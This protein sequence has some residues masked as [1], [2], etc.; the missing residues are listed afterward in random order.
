MRHLVEAMMIIFCFGAAI[1]YCITVGDILEPVRHLSYMPD[2]VRGPNGRS[3]VMV[4]FWFCLM[5]PLSLLRSVNSL[6]FSSFLGVTAIVFLV[7]ATIYHCIHHR[8]AWESAC[9]GSACE[10]C[11]GGWCTITE[12]ATPPSMSLDMFTS[13]PLIMFA[14][15]CQVNVYDIYRE[16]EDATEAK[17]MRISWVGMCGICLWVYLAMGVAGYLDF[18]GAIQGNILINLQYAVGQ[19]AVVTGAFIC[20]A[21]T[22]VVAFPLCV[23]PCRESIFSIMRGPSSDL[24]RDEMIDQFR[25]GDDQVVV[26]PAAR[27][28]VSIAPTPS[29]PEASLTLESASPR[30]MKPLLEEPLLEEAPMMHHAAF[31][32]PLALPS[33]PVEPEAYFVPPVPTRVYVRPGCCVHYTVSLAIS[34]GALAVALLCPGVQVIFSLLGGF[35][36]SFLCFVFPAMCVESLGVASASA[37]GKTTAAAIQFMKWGG[38]CAGF[39]STVLVII[40]LFAER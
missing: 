21:L 10:E 7:I 30:K 1:A 29:T 11:S 34:V 3:I 17:M 22:V 5:M 37:V 25:A 19:D 15:T 20:I 4:V 9:L 35:C 8:G 26:G 13:L 24:E 18:R 36:S 38:G 27:R 40:S 28:S 39:F 33:Y 16:L 12:A 23:F 31:M 2:I 6:Q 32:P 14:F